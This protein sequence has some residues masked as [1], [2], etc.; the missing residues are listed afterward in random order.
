IAVAQFLA[1]LL[2]RNLRCLRH[3]QASV[4]PSRQATSQITA[5]VFD[6]D[7]SQPQPSLLN[8]R[9]SITYQNRLGVN[10]KNAACPGSELARERDADRARHVSRCERFARTNIKQVRLLL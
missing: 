6:A 5:Q 2:G 3:R 4:L 9:V 10:A 8:L 7:T 1:Q